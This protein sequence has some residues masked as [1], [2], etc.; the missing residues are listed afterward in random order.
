MTILDELRGLDTSRRSLR[1]FGLVVGGVFLAIVAFVFW[2][3]GFEAT[4]VLIG[5][6]V[7]ASVLVLLAVVAPTVLK[8]AHRVWM[9]LALILGFVMTRVILTVMYYL[10]FTPIGLILRAFGRDPMNRS[11]GGDSYWIERTVVDESPARLTKYY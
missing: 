1:N 10:V 4:P 11:F 6:A 7:G 8:P 5:I 3:R 9:L 2:R